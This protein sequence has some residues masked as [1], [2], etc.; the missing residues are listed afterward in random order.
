MENPFIEKVEWK[1]L[2]I[3]YRL[4]F[5]FISYNRSTFVARSTN[6]QVVCDRE[7]SYEIELGDYLFPKI[8]APYL[9]LVLV[10]L[11]NIL[12]NCLWKTRWRHNAPIMIKDPCSFFEL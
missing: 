12:L 9:L 4:V 11:V 2:D 5:G 1:P 6:N 7:R 3:N 8:D 10:L